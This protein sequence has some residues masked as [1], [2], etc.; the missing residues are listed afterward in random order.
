MTNIIIAITILATYTLCLCVANKQIPSSLSASVFWLP[1]SGSWLWT[2]AIGAVAYLTMPALIL[3]T[4]ESYQ[5]LGF[6]SCAAL[7]VV[8]VCPLIRDKGDMSYKVH[9]GAAIVCAV[10]SQIIVAISCWW[11]LLLWIPWI[12]AFVWITKDHA[13]RT[14]TF[15]AEM[16]CFTISFIYVLI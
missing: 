9:T 7:A 15:W 8:A 1:P 10:C 11:L 13:W 3:K 14:Q 6:I 16:T 12:I 5:F 4:P 2:V